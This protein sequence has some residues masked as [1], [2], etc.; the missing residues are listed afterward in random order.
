MK[1]A[2]R[3]RKSGEDSVDTRSTQEDPVVANVLSPVEAAAAVKKK[4]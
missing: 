2:S 4:K 1:A 3:G